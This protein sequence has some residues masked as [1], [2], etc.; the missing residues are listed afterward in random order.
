MDYPVNYGEQV[1]VVPAAVTDHFLRLASPDALRVLMLYLR[2]APAGIPLAE[3]ADRLQLS[4]ETVED[5]IAF[6]TQANVLKTRGTLPVSSTMVFA[7]TPAPAP[8]EAPSVPIEMPAPA[9]P[10]EPI[11]TTKVLEEQVDPSYIA[12]AL[13]ASPKMRSFFSYVEQTIGQPLNH[14]ERK[15]FYLLHE[16][17][18]MS[19]EVLS[20]LVHYCKSIDKFSSGY[21]G[22]VAISWYNEGIMDLESAQAEVLRL[23]EAHSY[24]SEIRR[25]FDMHR[26]PTTKQMEF[27]EKW[28]AAGT[29]M[30]ILQ[31]AYE[32]TVEALP[33]WR[34]T[35]PVTIAKA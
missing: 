32:R 12:K 27:I 17:C 22:T 21:V 34:N 18:D 2:H 3:I 11:L 31:Y 28:K 6:W 33:G 1:F 8:A 16:K 26:K 13:E 29:P 7:P 19:T 24:V 35:S 4:Q 9:S 20:T 10:K 25:L 15:T 14:N 23:T 5:A 30:P